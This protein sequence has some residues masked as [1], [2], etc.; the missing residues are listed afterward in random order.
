LFVLPSLTEGLPR[1]LLE[2]M[3]R[4]LPAIATRVGGVPELL[5]SECLVPPGDTGALEKK[6]H[7]VMYDAAAL[8]VWARRNRDVALGYHERLLTPVRHAFLTAVRDAST[9][10]RAYGRA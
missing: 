5:P 1:A 8:N 4:G 6:I 10:P 7:D 9:I 3:A 2:A